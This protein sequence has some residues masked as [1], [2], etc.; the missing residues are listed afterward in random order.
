MSF[1]D[2]MSSGRG[3]GVIGMVMALVVLLG[4]GLLFMY[5]SD[6]S[7][8]GGQSIESLISHQAKEIDGHQATIIYEQK[9]LEQ[10]PLLISNSQ[11]LTRLKREIQSLK[12][13]SSNLAKRVEKGKSEIALKIQALAD[14]KNEYRAYARS[15]AKG[16][17]IAKLETLT[18][19][20]YNDVIIREVTAIGIQ[21]RHAD[22]QKRIP[23]E[24]LPEAMKD[25]FQFD[26]K[27]KE[28]A[29]AEESANRDVHEAAVAVA[30]DLAGQKMDE[31]RG[32][33]AEA[34]KAKIRLDITSK[35]G[36]IAS[37]QEDIKGLQ[38]DMDRAA[39]D[40]ASA[41]AAG[42]MHIN[43]SGSIGSNIRSKQGRI[44]TL[45]A[46]VVQMKARL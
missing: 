42:K 3:P 7:E 6:E 13:D 11:E 8:R 30:D 24:D 4:F 22:G 33:D 19:V 44:A 15:K 9:K 41:R 32:R 35:E 23:F 31:Q 2:M 36:L 20:V 27:Q 29:V 17:T 40:A 18:G 14:Y 26:P 28:Q 21:I 39:A 43:K 1:S 38:A 34:A 37:I 25:H 46:E 45:Q 16:E 12:N 5:A 10:A